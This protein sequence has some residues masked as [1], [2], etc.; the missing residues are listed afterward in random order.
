MK[1]KKEN[2]I[3]QMRNSNKQLE[4]DIKTLNTQVK[5]CLDNIENKEKN[6]KNEKDKNI[7][8]KS[9]EQQYKIKEKKLD[10]AIQLNKKYQKQKKI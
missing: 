4:Q 5:Q 3:E 6:D 10:D 1:L 2:V 9:Y 7:E 8:E